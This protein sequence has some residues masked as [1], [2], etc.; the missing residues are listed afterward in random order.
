MKTSILRIF[1]IVCL[2]LNLLEIQAQKYDIAQIAKF[3]TV[4]TIALRYF[5]ENRD[6]LGSPFS[7]QTVHFA[8][9]PTGWYAVHQSWDETKERYEIQKEIPIWLAKENR[10]FF[11]IAKDFQKEANYD[12]V[13]EFLKTQQ[14]NTI[15]HRQGIFYGYPFWY[16]DVIRILGAEKQLT[17]AQNLA[18][19]RAY[20][21]K[22]RMIMHPTALRQLEEY[23]DWV[24]Q[25]ETNFSTAF[26]LDDIIDA[27]IQNSQK[28]LDCL[29]AAAADP[30]LETVVGN[31]GL[32]YACEVTNAYWML[33]MVGREDEG[34]K[35]LTES[36]FNPLILDYANRT[37]NS[38]PPNAIIFTYG[39]ADTYPLI[40]LQAQKKIRPDVQIINIGLLDTGRYLN[41]LQKKGIKI[42]WKP[43]IYND[44]AKSYQLFEHS[45][46]TIISWSELSEHFVNEKS[47]TK[48]TGSFYIP[49]DKNTPTNRALKKAYP[50]AAWQDSIA[51]NGSIAFASKGELAVYEIVAQNIANRPIC[52]ASSVVIGHFA[53]SPLNLRFDGFIYS[54]LPLDK[55]LM[56]EIPTAANTWSKLSPFTSK[57]V[58]LNTHNTAI[59]Y[60]YIGIALYLTYHY[61]GTENFPKA[62]ETMQELEKILPLNEALKADFAV[63]FCTYYEKLGVPEKAKP[64]IKAYLKELANKTRSANAIKDGSKDFLRYRLK[65][66]S[67]LMREF[68]IKHRF[69]KEWDAEIKGL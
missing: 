38:C 13:I 17:P 64:Y 21:E 47:D 24:R 34:K 42:S 69:T 62:L 65:K 63:N 2:L 23:P 1:S 44:F 4:E 59:L 32:K 8:M 41:Y 36:A 14:T 9:K 26:I 7:I 40:Y 48:I 33:E 18:L 50:D 54:L 43:S 35:F 12:E 39:D 10:F 22:A 31:I 45:K 53:F 49:F 3:P 28:E 29:K 16:E 57:E 37:L 52:F 11:E 55:N 66:E 56:N 5:S 19:A 68:C 67:A 58:A 25:Y 20:S 30:H 15:G 61:K 27:F 6:Y 51:S 46:D 60:Q